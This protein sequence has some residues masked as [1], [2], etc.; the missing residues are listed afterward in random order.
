MGGEELLSL[1]TPEGDL[2]SSC[3]SGCLKGL[4]AGSSALT[5][6]EESIHTHPISQDHNDDAWSRHHTDL[7]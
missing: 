6:R 1:F 3:I 7:A 4:L 2:I 5:L